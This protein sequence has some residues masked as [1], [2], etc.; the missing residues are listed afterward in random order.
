M[1]HRWVELQKVG[2]VGLAGMFLAR[3]VAQGRPARAQGSANKQE[4]TEQT[5]NGHEDPRAGET[6]RRQTAPRTVSQSTLQRRTFGKEAP[7]SSCHT[8]EAL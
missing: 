8:R 2:R 4:E 1:R 6:Q 7:H 5:K 3:T